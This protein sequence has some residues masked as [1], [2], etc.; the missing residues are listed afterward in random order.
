MAA[1]ITRFPVRET[2][3]APD[4]AADFARTLADSDPV[5]ATRIFEA[6]GAVL[7]VT[8]LEASRP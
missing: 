3:A 7:G 8:V 5:T 6:L 1:T 4:P 2:A